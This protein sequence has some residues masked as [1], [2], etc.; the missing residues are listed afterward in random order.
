MADH[1]QLPRNFKS[2]DFAEWLAS[3]LEREGWT[4]EVRQQ[5]EDWL[6]EKTGRTVFPR[7]PR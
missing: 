2:G 3:A 5:V 6:Y 1:K 7:E 4:R